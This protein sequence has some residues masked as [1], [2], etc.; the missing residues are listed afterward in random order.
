MDDKY[1][2]IRDSLASLRGMPTSSVARLVATQWL[3]R[4]LETEGPGEV[5]PEALLDLVETMTFG[6]PTPEVFGVFSRLVRI[7]DEHPEWF[8]KFDQRNFFWEYK[9]LASDISDYPQIGEEQTQAF[10][11]EML[12]R[13]QVAG[14]SSAAID[15][16]QFQLA[17]DR[18]DY[19]QAKMWRERYLR[20]G[21]DEFLCSAC[22]KSDAS[23]YFLKVNELDQA[24]AAGVPSDA[25]CNR[26]PDASNRCLAEAHLHRG[27][28][29]EAARYLRTAQA[30]R[31]EEYDPKTLGYEFS[32]LAR[33]GFLN[34]ALVLLRDQ[35]GKL[36]GGTAAPRTLMEGWIYV[37]EGISAALNSS[38]NPAE[39]EAMSTAIMQG[40]TVGELL[41]CAISRAEPIAQGFDRRYGNTFTT[42]C[43][44][45][46][47]KAQE[48]GKLDFALDTTPSEEVQA[49]SP[50]DDAGNSDNV[51]SA[52]TQSSVKED[53]YQAGD[54]HLANREYAQAAVCYIQ[55][56]EEYKEQ[57]L[58]EQA[59][60]ALADAAQCYTENQEYSQSLTY[61]AQAWKFLKAGDASAELLL[62]I[63]GAWGTTAERVNQTH[64]LEEPA[65]TLAQK[66]ES[67]A[68]QGEAIDQ[69]IAKEHA[70]QLGA[71]YDITARIYASRANDPREQADSKA[72]TIQAI[73]YAQR[74]AEVLVEHRDAVGAGHAYELI[75]KLQGSLGDSTTAIDNIERALDAYSRFNRRDDSSRAIDLVIEILKEAGEEAR[76]AE[77]LAEVT[78][79]TDASFTDPDGE[80]SV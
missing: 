67:S 70:R 36:L 29:R 73:E 5:L 39:V 65:A 16:A 46:A 45:V 23:R 50:R 76:L 11:K 34:E 58:I 41:E 33:G 79:L 56:S 64:L 61:F 53:A 43:I 78:G 26:Q 4:K 49:D 44:A 35:G 12:E 54:R 68:P 2:D 51:N 10:L 31:E 66:I 14:H 37:I 30:T 47:R 6:A 52:A 24:I 3:V 8:D 40:P 27:N 48:L 18:G 7:Y 17:M 28:G 32:I 71:I 13:Y 42:D 69:E 15:E 55:A 1:S 60:C 75:G 77:I 74:C 38:E 62:A 25:Q 9:W 19:E 59:G 22:Q 63:L 21:D 72:L 20:A 57:G 80:P